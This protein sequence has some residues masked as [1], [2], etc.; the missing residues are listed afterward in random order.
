MNH[1]L[2]I[3]IGILLFAVAS[4]TL[5]VIGLRKK[6]H[7]NENLVE[8]LLNNGAVRVRKYLKEHDTITADGIGYVIED[9]KAREFYSKKMATIR[10]GADFQAQLIDYM[11]RRNYLTEDK[12]DKGETVYRLP[13]KEGK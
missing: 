3:I 12:N 4:A 1:T 5:Y 10:N 6:M 11:L 7:E 9:V 8:M 2:Y 13:P